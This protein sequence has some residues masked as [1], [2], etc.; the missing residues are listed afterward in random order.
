M[1]KLDDKP[2]DPLG[3]IPDSSAPGEFGMVVTETFTRAL[4]RGASVDEAFDAALGVAGNRS[5][6][7][8]RKK[9]KAS[10]GMPSKPIDA[11][12]PLGQGDPVGDA[13]AR[14]FAEATRR[15]ASP[16]EAFD[17][18]MGAAEDSARQVGM[19]PAVF[20]DGLRLAAKAFRR[21]RADGASAR[22]AMLAAH[23]AA[24]AASPPAAGHSRNEPNRD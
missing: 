4:D 5:R 6:F 11:G 8:A 3:R 20:E 13:A 1:T 24:G 19:N 16:E 21:A 14:A 10:T 23:D 7:A 15:G 18:A 22:D 9:T 12:N 17:A 2:D